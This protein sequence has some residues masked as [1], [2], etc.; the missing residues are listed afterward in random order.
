M[1]SINAKNYYSQ[2]ANKEFMSV[3]QF[4]TFT[5]C[6]ARAL[7]ELNGEYKRPESSAL[8]LGSYV[9]EMLTG[10]KKSQAKFIEDNHSNLFKKNGDPYADVLKAI[11]AVERVKKQPLMMKYLSGTKQKI[12]TG[13]IGGIPWKIKMD[14]YKPGEFIADL[15]YLKDLR[16]PNLFESAIKYWGYDIQMA[17]YQEIV[18]QNTGE[19]LPTYLVIVTK[20]TVPRVAVAEVN[21]WNLISAME[22]VQK[23]LPR[24]VA[25]KNG[26]VAPERCGDCDFCADT[27]VLT[28]PIDSDLL[29]MSAKQREAMQGKL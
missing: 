22:N 27:E 5:Q 29:G 4:K 26:E 24:I 1:K 23:Q 25:V 3:S 21:S 12:M 2:T 8:F 28:E 7:A 17:V 6:E 20:E 13:E 11:D 15:K 18:Y 14:S 9:D 10:T 16:S 19:R